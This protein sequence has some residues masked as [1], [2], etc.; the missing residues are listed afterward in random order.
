M[1]QL[2]EVKAPDTG[3]EDIGKAPYCVMRV[4]TGTVGNQRR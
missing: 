3:D 1:S 2:I 4:W